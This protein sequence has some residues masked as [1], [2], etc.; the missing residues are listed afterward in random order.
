MQRI[1]VA[2]ALRRLGPEC[3]RAAEIRRVAAR[4]VAQEALV[5]VAEREL[6]DLANALRRQRGVAAALHE[7]AGLVEERHHLA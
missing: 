7:I 1:A 6:A 2:E 3:R 5:D 4:T